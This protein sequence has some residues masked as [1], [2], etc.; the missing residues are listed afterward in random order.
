[1]PASGDH[2]LWFDP[3]WLVIGVAAAAFGLL[4]SY[5]VRLGLA[6]GALFS[7]I[8]LAWLYVALRYGSLSGRP[9]SGREALVARFQSQTSNR[10][11]AALRTAEV[12]PVSGPEQGAE[13]P[14]RP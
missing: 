8:G 6:S 10:R 11:I 5:D 7:V 2:G 1:M 4:L 13:P 14:H 12:D 9:A 3:K